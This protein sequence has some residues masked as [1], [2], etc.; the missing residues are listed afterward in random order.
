MGRAAQL[1]GAECHQPLDSRVSTQSISL[2]TFR[3]IPLPTEVV[4]L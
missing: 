1:Q 4:E 2:G 3:V